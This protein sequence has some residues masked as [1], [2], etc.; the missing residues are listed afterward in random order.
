MS[1]LADVLQPERPLV[2][3][4]TYWPTHL[5]CPYCPA[6]ATPTVTRGAVER[7]A[8]RQYMCPQFHLFLAYAEKSGD[9]DR[10]FPGGN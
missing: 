1:I 8:V 5:T 3:E 2:A 6:Q 9:E 7:K 4:V 10:T